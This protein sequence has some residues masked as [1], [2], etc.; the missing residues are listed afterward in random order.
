MPRSG[1]GTQPRIPLLENDQFTYDKTDQNAIYLVEEAEQK[2]RW[3]NAGF[4]MTC[5]LCGV[6]VLSMPWAFSQLGWI[7]G[8]ILFILIL[9]M[10][11]YTCILLALM[12]EQSGRRFNR[13]SDLGSHLFGKK[14]TNLTIIPVQFFVFVGVQIVYSIVA[15]QVLKQSFEIV[16]NNQQIDQIYFQIIFGVIQV[17]F[18]QA[19]N[20]HSISILSIVGSIISMSYSAIAIIAAI[21][22]GFPENLDYADRETNFWDRLSGI[23][24]AVGIFFSSFMGQNVVLEIQASLRQKNG[25]SVPSMLPGLIFTYSACCVLYLAV[26][27]TGFAAYGT[28]VP[29]NIM[30]AIQKPSWMVIVANFGIFLHVT[31]AYQILNQVVY[32]SIELYMQKNLKNKN[33]CFLKCFVRVFYVVCTI[34]VG[35]IFPYFG[36]ILGLIG[37]ISIGFNAFVIP[38]VLWILSGKMDKLKWLINVPLIF[39]GGLGA[40]VCMFGSVRSI[41]VNFLDKNS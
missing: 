31:A 27:L 38:N 19:P 37:A 12:H 29:D 21:L 24:S 34:V 5:V 26:G 8:I 1:R 35:I 23:S 39:V 20:L 2:G 25:S 16:F 22:H 30:L 32:Y 17:F 11:A 10:S 13:Y 36:N 4:H 9:I 6:G 15:G 3:Y 33:Q 28:N 7:L 41:I 40:L 14:I 18:S